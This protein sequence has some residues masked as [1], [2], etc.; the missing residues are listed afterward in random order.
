MIIPDKS[1]IRY[2]R[3]FESA[4]FEYF[5]K[6]PHCLNIFPHKNM[7]TLIEYTLIESAL[8][9]DLLY[10]PPEEKKN[11]CNIINQLANNKA[12]RSPIANEILAFGWLVVLL[13]C[14]SLLVFRCAKGRRSTEENSCV[15]LWLHSQ[16][17]LQCWKATFCPF[18]IP[19][20]ILWY[21]L[22]FSTYYT[23]QCY[24]IQI[25]LAITSAKNT[26]IF[27]NIDTTPQGKPS[28]SLFCNRHIGIIYLIS[29][30]LYQVVVVQIKNRNT[31]TL[32]S[33]DYMQH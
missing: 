26:Y 3:V 19:T 21:S 14:V 8:F 33:P 9:E 13:F 4:L 2:S 1:F 5:P 24:R 25:L 18:S 30:L 10:N 20:T 27:T 32:Y 12:N 29:Y 7:T 22:E 28:L 17:W 6:N 11:T 31:V 15:G 16:N 23:Y